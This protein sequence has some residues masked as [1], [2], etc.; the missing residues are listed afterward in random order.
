M[1]Q[2]VIQKKKLFELVSLI[3]DVIR[4]PIS[5]YDIDGNTIS[6]SEDS[7][8]HYS[9]FCETLRHTNPAFEKMCIQC[10]MVHIRQAQQKRDIVVYRCHAGLY[11]CA[12]PV[13][14]AGNRLLG[15]FLVGQLRVQSNMQ[16]GFPK[17]YAK[18]YE[19]MEICSYD[20]IFRTGLLLKKLVENILSHGLVGY[21]RKPWAEALELYLREHCKKNVTLK[22]AAHFLGLSSSFL[23]HRF[24]NEF[25][26]TFKEYARNIRM[27]EAAKLLMQ[28]SCVKQ[29]AE[30]LGFPDPYTFS[31]MFKRYWGEPPLRYLKKKNIRQKD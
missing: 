18:L 17:Q 14:D 1:E 20:H 10:D 29:T 2:Y 27:E 16:T 12:I 25:Q 5:F 13:L 7:T 26:M 3:A 8:V 22:E 28:T 23:T 31:K 4:K 11:E 19:K 6:L 21:Y 15:C 30:N 9:E 24:R